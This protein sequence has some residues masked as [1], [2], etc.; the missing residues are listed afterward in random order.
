MSATPAEKKSGI[1][2][3][4]FGDSVTVTVKDTWTGNVRVTETIPEIEAGD[5][6]DYQLDVATKNGT[7]V[8]SIPVDIILGIAA[9]FVR[10]ERI[11]ELEE[12]EDDIML[13]MGLV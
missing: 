9:E 11:R 12:A 6:I 8:Y 5:I 7:T 3:I 10:Q 1:V 4:D 2:S 13:L